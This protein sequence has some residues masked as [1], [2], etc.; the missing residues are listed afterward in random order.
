[1]GED[2]MLSASQIFG[3]SGQV[4]AWECHGGLDLLGP[5]Q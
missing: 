1:M 5:P 3:D 4:S 2:S